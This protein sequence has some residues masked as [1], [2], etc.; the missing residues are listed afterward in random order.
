[1][2][3]VSRRI[4]RAKAGTPRF[5]YAASWGIAIVVLLV[6][7]GAWQWRA[8]RDAHTQVVELQTK[9]HTDR[10]RTAEQAAG[11]LAYIGQVLLE[12][13]AHSENSI[14]KKALPRLRDGLETTK[15][16]VIDRS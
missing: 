7:L 10:V 2:D 3:R 6:A 4:A 1:M 13:T 11:A 8:N 9:A 15:N 5:G 14:L 16:K 12:T